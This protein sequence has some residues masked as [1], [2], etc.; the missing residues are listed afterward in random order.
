MVLN[1]LDTMKKYRLDEAIRH[2]GALIVAYS[3]GADSS[4]LLHLLHSFCRTEKIPL[5]AAHVNHGIRG[6]EA[7]AD[8]E[9]CRLTCEKLSIPLSVLHVDV[10]ALAAEQGKGIEETARLVRYDFFDQIS[11][12]LTDHP[13]GAL[14]A[15]AHNA[16]DNLETVL[17]H[18]LRGTGLRGLC[19]IDPIRDGLYIRPLLYDS[20]DDI[21]TWCRENSVPYVVDS[22]NTDTA[23]TRNYI[24]HEV[25]PCLKKLCP[26]PQAAVS[27]MTT[28]LREDNDYL[29][30]AAASLVLSGET[31][32]KKETVKN[33]PP[34]VMSRVFR[35][36]YDNAKPSD[37]SLEEVHISAIRDLLDHSTGEKSLSLPGKITFRI[38]GEYLRFCQTEA[39]PSPSE[40]IFEYPRDG[41]CFENERYLLKIST[42]DAAGHK[43]FISRGENIYKLSILRT[44]CSDK[45]IGSLIVRHRR[46]GDTYRFGH[47]TRKVKKLF[48][49]NKMTSEQKNFI[50][51]VCDD[52]GILWIPGFPPRDGTEAVSKDCVDVIHLLCYERVRDA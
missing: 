22:T 48:I 11:K 38:E 17:F 15:T 10:P 46:S 43:T 27:R 7:D 9:F 20:G 14:I 23:Y 40:V 50:P 42:Q 16:D 25:V 5:F 47:M 19:G 21:R 41:E 39:P 33:L 36:L 18:M 4:C 6:S 32:I 30:K 3:G 12:K 31:S 26:A 8:E 37:T 35:L 13:S 2:R 24:R 45:I 51:I 49:D 29:E 34:A 44:I 28:L 52:D 1:F